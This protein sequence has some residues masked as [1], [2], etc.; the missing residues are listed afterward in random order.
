MTKIETLKLYAMTAKFVNMKQ[1][2]FQP[3]SEQLVRHSSIGIS[4]G[5]VKSQFL[6]RF[7]VEGDEKFI[8][9]TRRC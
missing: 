1:I 4:Y 3:F 2:W 6:G 8:C 7:G 9:V 5:C